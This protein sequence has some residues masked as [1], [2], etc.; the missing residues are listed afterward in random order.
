METGALLTIPGTI[1]Q[2]PHD[3]QPSLVCANI[4]SGSHTKFSNSKAV[5]PNEIWA[6]AEEAHGNPNAS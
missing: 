4:H 1:S 5:H 2:Q 6:K 3:L